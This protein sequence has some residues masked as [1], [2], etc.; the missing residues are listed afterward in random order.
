MKTATAHA[1]TETSP[2]HTGPVCKRCGGLTFER[3][4]RMGFLQRRILPFFN[5]YPWRC[6]LCNKVHYRGARNNAELRRLAQR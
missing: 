6:V 5:L 4:Q 2:P 1:L 3:L